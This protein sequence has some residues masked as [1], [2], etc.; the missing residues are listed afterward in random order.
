MPGSSHRL[1][2]AS[3]VDVFPV[4]ARQGPLHFRIGA[5]G[6]RWLDG[7]VAPFRW[8]ERTIDGVSLLVLRNPETGKERA[9][10]LNRIARRV[11]RKM[12]D[13][14]QYPEYI[15]PRCSVSKPINNAWI[16]AELPD[17]PYIKK[18][19][20]NLRCTFDLRLQFEGVTTDDRNALLGR[21]NRSINQ[22]SSAREISRLANL[23]ELI[24]KAKD[25]PMIHG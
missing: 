7:I 3:L 24:T 1:G 9:V 8:N 23:V 25:I 6:L 19:I 11:V 21:F 16:K 5:T 20:H 22:K 13:L 12:R 14:G 4:R 10:I 18:G 17:E 15:F 2:L